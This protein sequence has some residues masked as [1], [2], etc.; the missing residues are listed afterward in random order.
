MGHAVNY[1]SFPA[2]KSVQEIADWV[3]ETV[4]NSGDGYGTD[5][6][7]ELPGICQNYEEAKRRIADADVNSFYGGFAVKYRDVF[8]TEDSATAEDLQ[9]RAREM[10][11]KHAAY[12]AAHSILQ[13][14]AD[15]IGCPK[16]GSKLRRERLHA[17]CCPLCGTDL[18]SPGVIARLLDLAEK[19]RKL[20]EKYAA[21]KQKSVA[22]AKV[23]WLVKYEYHI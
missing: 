9:R 4:C 7:R 23:R 22:N 12:G 3:S 15:F 17:E 18:R 5:S 13:R 21:E 19:A 20:D 11:K 10:R 14:K 8:S 6:I 2:E 16:C 1:K